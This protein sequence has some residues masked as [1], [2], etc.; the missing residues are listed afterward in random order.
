MIDSRPSG[1]LFG[2]VPDEGEVPFGALTAVVV[3]VTKEM[4]NVKMKEIRTFPSALHNGFF[5]IH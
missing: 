2:E 4:G 1:V 5:I 3:R